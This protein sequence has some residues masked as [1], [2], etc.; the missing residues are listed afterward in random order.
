MRFIHAQLSHLQDSANQC[1]VS[2]KTN[3]KVNLDCQ[4]N[5]TQNRRPACCLILDFPFGLVNHQE[6]TSTF[7]LKRKKENKFANPN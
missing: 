4:V 2:S 7:I 3:E 5:G 1:G 6:I